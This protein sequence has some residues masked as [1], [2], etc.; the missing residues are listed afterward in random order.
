MQEDLSQ[1]VLDRNIPQLVKLLLGTTAEG[2]AENETQVED[3]IL[4]S[5]LTF[6][7]DR[8]KEENP[9]FCPQAVW[10][11][12]NHFLERYRS[13]QLSEFGD[14]V[15]QLANVVLNH[16]LCLNHHQKDLQWRILDFMLSVNYQAFRAI[17]INRKEMQQKRIDILEAL[18]SANESLEEQRSPQNEFPVERNLRES[19]ERSPGPA[20]PVPKS[21][22]HS[23]KA[24]LR[25]RSWENES[26]LDNAS[27]HIFLESSRPRENS[28]GH[29]VQVR[30]YFST[31]EAKMNLSMD[32][33]QVDSPEEKPTKV[34]Y[35]RGTNDFL[36]RIYT[37]WWQVDVHVHHQPRTLGCGFNH[38]YGEWLLH[39]LRQSYTS[40]RRTTEEHQLLREL[41][42]LFFAPDN[43]NH[44]LL[45]D[46]G[47]KLRGVEIQST[48]L[49]Q[50]V[51]GTLFGQICESLEHMRQLRTFINCYATPRMSGYRV[52]TLVSFGVA[53]RR[54]LR[55][56]I[57]YLIF[58]ERRLGVGRETPTLEHFVELSKN[59]LRRLKILSEL[60][61]TKLP[62]KASV[63]SLRIL[64]SLV[65]NCSNP[66]QEQ[67]S[68]S[69]ALLLHSL[70]AFCNFLDNWWSTG[71]FQDWQEEFPYRKLL[72][73]DRLEY[74]LTKNLNNKKDLL[75][76]QIIKIIQSH[77]HE[78]RE[79]VAT[80]YTTCKMGDFTALHGSIVKV[81]LHNMLME[82]V[83][84][85][86]IPY[87]TKNPEDVYFA[88]DILEQLKGI[89]QEPMRRML[90][91]FHM[92][93]R[94]DPQQ[95][96]RCSVDEMVRNFQACSSYTPIVEIIAQQLG[97]QLR[98]R[99]ILANAFVDHL[100]RKEMKVHR[101]A[102]HLRSVFLLL[103]YN[104]HQTQFEEFFDFLWEKKLKQAEQ[105]LKEIVYA[106][107]PIL[108]YLFHVR[109]SRSH[110]DGIYLTIAYDAFLNRVISQ[111][112]FRHLNECFR[113]ILSVLWT[114]YR[115]KKLLFLEAT[116]HKK[117]MLALHAFRCYLIE[118]LEEQLSHPGKLFEL[119]D[120][121]KQCEE[122]LKDNSTIQELRKAQELFVHQ[123][124]KK[125]REELPGGGDFPHRIGELLGACETLQKLWL[126]ASSIISSP[127]R[128]T[129][130][131]KLFWL[132]LFFLQSILKHCQFMT[133][134][135][136]QL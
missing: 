15:K 123:T 53:I 129:C 65:T 56:V 49:S 89:E 13:E 8:L 75:D 71:E 98:R 58:F 28:D 77:V 113:L 35:Y 16:P 100:V 119:V 95:P 45:L 78:S 80:L 124:R 4:E 31:P 121:C 14:T 33:T 10:N 101:T 17:R 108:G 134:E 22:K 73:D 102:K 96:A 132:R 2:P 18:A 136:E 81:S 63:C 25:S 60:I 133:S 26:T 23:K 59:S 61:Q 99:S 5:C 131:I 39:Q 46:Q 27:A 90:Y 104:L 107:D 126:R 79:A 64:E 84:K 114:V 69:A 88:P 85:E 117:I 3:N 127:T 97:N 68:L 47:M 74:V 50:L 109:L 37:P 86:L 130:R 30:E 66:S 93:T 42:I 32:L 135:L 52:E 118:V 34:N 83:L 12:M 105:K 62:E 94:P 125:L 128:S 19:P 43:F 36:S 54:L 91:T 67:R 111:S 6:A 24:I 122:S 112:Q 48:A 29:G 11:N 44:F 72:V 115:L 116:K 110:P 51:E 55:P 9:D 120:I 76:G 92:D 87:Q 7:N 20:S 70:Q 57:E 38:S 21:R 40:V 41:V 1:K 103:N 106:Q 82:S